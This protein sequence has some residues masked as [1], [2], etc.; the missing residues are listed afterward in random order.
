M[1]LGISEAGTEA[2][3]HKTVCQKVS[4]KS[5]FNS[6]LVPEGEKERERAKIL[7][8]TGIVLCPSAHFMVSL[9]NYHP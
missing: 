1:W 5:V 9:L 3:W 6:S 4:G 8:G 2:H 7:V